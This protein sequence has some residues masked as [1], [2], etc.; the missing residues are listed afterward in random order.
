MMITF[1]GLMIGSTSVAALADAP[2]STVLWDKPFSS[3]P[4]SLANNT[5]VL[6]LITNDDPFDVVPGGWAGELMEEPIAEV[7]QQ[8]IG[9]RDRLATQFLPTGIPSSLTAGEP[10]NLPPRAVV[11]ICNSDYRLLSLCVGIPETNELSALIEDAEEVQTLMGIPNDDPSELIREL[12]ERSAERVGRRWQQWI[13]QA[14]TDIENNQA[15]EAVADRIDR[16]GQRFEQAYLA[17]ARLRF[18]LSD[19]EDYTRLGLL[20]QH[21]STRQPWCDSMIPLIANTDLRQHYRKLIQPIW[22]HPPVD[23]AADA[24]ELI[25]WAATH[26]DQ[27]A[28]E[29]QGTFVLSLQSPIANAMTQKRGQDQAND[30]GKQNRVTKAWDR[31]ASSVQ[32]HPNREVN[33]QELALLSRA[34]QWPAIDIQRPSMARYI[35]VDAAKPT[36]LVVH[37]TD[38]PGRFAAVLQ[39]SKPSTKSKL[40]PDAE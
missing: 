6:L 16:L 4:Q 25:D 35:F 24:S 15:D 33:L 36:P 22:G 34:Q 32:L 26:I 23:A 10:R 8:R 11:A 40:Q 13:A 5:L 20:E 27:A 14:V 18:G 37:V 29:K 3:Q 28:T 39:R 38:P 19:P 21:V 30:A 31:V 7:S 17:E 12:A 2:S 1:L 9:L